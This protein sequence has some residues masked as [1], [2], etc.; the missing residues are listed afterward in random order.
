MKLSDIRGEAALDA[1]CD[2]ID[3]I[4]EITKDSRLVALIRGRKF[5]DAVKIGIKE[6]KKPVLTILAILN[7]QPP[8]EFSPS[9]PE[10]PAMLLEVLNDPDVAVLFQSQDQSME[11]TS[12]GPATENTEANE[13]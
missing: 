1:I 8:E 6:H 5:L 12:S 13:A 7:Q 2:L 11:E 3:P 4:S 9:L 10:I